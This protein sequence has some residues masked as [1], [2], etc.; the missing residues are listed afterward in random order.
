MKQTNLFNYRLGMSRS[1]IAKPLGFIAACLAVFFMIG[2]QGASAQK[3][4]EL[5]EQ[6]ADHTITL[7]KGEMEFLQQEVKNPVGSVNTTKNGQFNAYYQNVLSQFMKGADLKDAFMNV[8][9]INTPV[10]INSSNAAGTFAALG[11][12]T[13]EIIIRPNSP[14]IKV[15]G[16]LVNGLN[17][18]D[19]DDSDLISIFNYLRTL[20]NQ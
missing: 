10:D 17:L 15:L 12:Q 19:S 13:S 5:S 2:L 20:K 7:I 9:R 6:G 16:S 18:I 8:D 14:E 3:M 11:Q 1:G 4:V